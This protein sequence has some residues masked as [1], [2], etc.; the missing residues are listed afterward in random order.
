MAFDVDLFRF[1]PFVRGNFP[2]NSFTVIR[3][4]YK[5]TSRF[6]DSFYDLY[7]AFIGY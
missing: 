5:S 4:Y 2:L 1:F 6:D 7:D 3:R